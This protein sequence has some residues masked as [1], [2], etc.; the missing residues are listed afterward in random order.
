VD[1]DESEAWARTP[2]SEQAVLDVLGL[3]RFFQQGIRLEID[4]SERQVIARSP[5]CMNLSQFF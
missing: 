2:V 5:V 4:H 3:Q 1:V